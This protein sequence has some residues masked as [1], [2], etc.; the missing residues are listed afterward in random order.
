MINYLYLFGTDKAD[1][2][3]LVYSL[4]ENLIK[5]NKKNKILEIGI[6]GHN[7]EYNGGDSLIGL[8]NYYIRSKIYG[9]DINDKKFLNFSNIRTFKVD[10]SSSRD[11]N[12]AI[13][14]IGHLDLIIDDGS[15]YVNHQMISFNT[16]F[17]KLKYNGVYIIED[18]SGSYKNSAFGSPKL[19]KQKNLYSY[20]SYYVHSMNYHLLTNNNKKKYKVFRE[21]GAIYFMRECILIIKS[22]NNL[23]KFTDKE[24]KITF[25]K[26]N[27]L[28]NI[29]K[30]IKGY[31]IYK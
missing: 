12:K 25:N 11:L 26:K 6:G 20:F 23:K 16:L 22:K 18:C 10:Q 21:I 9:F 1:N 31:F 29:K 3:P 28:R 15:H 19:T 30:D 4:L 7:K 13:S 2:Y 8:S 5:K 27:S 17:K 24:L 14:K